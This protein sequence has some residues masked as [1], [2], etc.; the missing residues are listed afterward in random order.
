MSEEQKQC[1]KC[2]TVKPMSSFYFRKESGKHRPQCKTCWDER[3]KAWHAANPDSRKKHRDKW[4]SAHP[5]HVLKRKA[6]HRKRHPIGYRK[7]NLEN[8]ERVKAIN[9]AWAANNMPARAAHAAKRR[10]VKKQAY[11][12]Y[13]AE[14][15]ELIEAE[16]FD[17][18]KRR[19]EAT[20]LAWEVDHIVPL[21]S[22][23][24]FGLH[25]EFNLAVIPAA[26]N[27]RKSNRVWPD[28]P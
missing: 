9:A 21:Q 18:A 5:G 3:V 2:G 14:L 7:W 8:P 20:G 6:A 1:C 22:K 15:F 19:T 11:C 17:L 23:I 4:E 13:D 25:N 28:M 12:P 24:V 27:R 10:A 26:I 16:A